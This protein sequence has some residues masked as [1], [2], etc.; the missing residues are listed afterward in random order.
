[1]A[2]LTEKKFDFRCETLPRD[3]FGVVEF[4]G[5]EGLSI[6]YRFDILLVSR[7]PKIDFDSVVQRPATLTLYREKGGDVDFH[8]ILTDFEQLHAVDAFVFYRATLVPK[9]WWLT[10]T[11]HNQVF[12]DDTVEEISEAVLLD[13]GLTAN[14]YEFRLENIY[15]QTRFVCQYGETH[16]NF[17]SRRLERDGI[18]YFFEQ[19]PD[20]EKIIFTDT[21]ISQEAC[22]F[23]GC[24]RYA[25]PS[26]L[27]DIRRTESI[28]S[29]T[30]RQGVV[31]AKIRLKDYNYRKPS[32][33]LDQEAVVDN[34]AQGE[35]Y[36]Y[37]EH[38]PS[39]AEGNRL[40]KI[41]ADEIICR[42]REFNGESTIPCLEPGFSF[43]MENHYRHSFN[44]KYLTVGVTHQ[45]SQTGYLI[46]GI[47]RGL[48]DRES[49]VYYRNQFSAIPS[50]VQ[51]RPRRK[52]LQ[53]KV[54]G[55][56]P[57]KIDA[58]GSGEYAELDEHG[59]Y[60][61]ILPF[62][63]SG[64]KDGKA[65][66]WLRMAQPYGG[67]NQG[68]HFPL[69]KHTEVLL[70]F[71]EGNPD[72]PIIASAVPNLED[73][74][75]LVT[76]ENQTKSVIKTGRG[77]KTR[78]VGAEWYD[79]GQS[80]DNILVL[81]DMKDNQHVVLHS[82]GNL[83]LEARGNS[84]YVEN[85]E[86]DDKTGFG[87]Y[88]GGILWE[89][90]DSYRSPP[91]GIVGI[92]NNLYGFRPSG[93]DTPEGDPAS[94]PEWDNK[95]SYS[96]GQIVRHDGKLYK[97]TSID[98]THSNPNASP[99]WSIIDS[100]E[101]EWVNLIDRGH[102]RAERMDSFVRHEG[103]IYDFG[104][105]RNYNFGG[106]YSENNMDLNAKLNDTEL[107]Q[108]KA[109]RVG[110]ADDGKPEPQPCGGPNFEYI[111]GLKDHGQNVWVSKKIK[112]AKYDYATETPS[113]E[114]KHDCDTYKYKY[115][116]K[117]E[118]Y[119]FTAGGVRRYKGI[120]EHGESWEWK[121]YG[122]SGLESSYTENLHYDN[123]KGHYTFNRHASE[124]TSLT[125]YAAA[126]FSLDMHLAASSSIKI[127]GAVN[128]NV[129]IN[130]GLLNKLTMVIGEESSVKIN[131]AIG[132]KVDLGASLHFGLKG[133]LGG[134]LLYNWNAKE[135]Q[136]WFPLTKLQKDAEVRAELRKILFQR[137][138]FNMREDGFQ[139]FRIQA[140][141]KTGKLFANQHELQLFI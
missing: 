94:A 45:G 141:V 20:S 70:T 135:F 54:S 138:V 16:F 137:Q 28:Q 47:K 110:E 29:F 103:N 122:D 121:Y 31:P 62:D 129:D 82:N 96:K 88:V 115:G 99:H 81:D 40:A 116:G 52:T 51:F 127:H 48:A 109:M 32:L 95:E 108:D 120:F 136:A 76:G 92:L 65:S 34:N 27:D 39:P 83:S 6:L 30:C 78:S 101:W 111:D 2:F 3:T 87:E 17:L 60:K 123:G 140:Q 49:D 98:G 33:T 56:L 53:P 107:E 35:I 86:E 125:F 37:G 130:P 124:K 64:R 43:D 77:P 113:M 18:Y 58:Q 114:V 13:A 105:Y 133:H 90:D 36:Y 73:Q 68:M 50:D 59:R 38:F 91:G 69:H 25:P 57:G 21:A 139:A 75:S 23:E 134:D 128:L 15:P 100:E 11:H 55:T 19:G 118:E 84:R 4:Q 7:D 112:G 41:R 1:M 71:V 5:E 106:T 85:N 12:L 44:Q 132:L 89:K 117:V 66:H 79:D 93:F 26:G 119:K 63:L 61:V 14:D 10:M 42:K 46:S 97:C 22:T 9:L 131:A 80:G 102:V 72:R 24:M 126:S 104:G 67:E 8:G 74:R